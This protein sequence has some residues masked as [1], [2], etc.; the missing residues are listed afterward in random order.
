MKHLIIL[1]LIAS[2]PIIAMQKNQNFKAKPVYEEECIAFGIP[3]EAKPNEVKSIKKQSKR[4]GI[5]VTLPS[6]ST[7]LKKFNEAGLGHFAKTT[8]FAQ[9]LADRTVNYPEGLTFFITHY[10]HDYQMKGNEISAI[11]VKNILETM[12]RPN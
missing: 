11:Q 6:R 5:Y 7:I 3:Y 8:G 12:Y 9:K 2:T 10:C 4:H 1:L